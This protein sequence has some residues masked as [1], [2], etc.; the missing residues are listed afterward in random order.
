MSY[1]DPIVP[2]V[3]YFY[4]HRKGLGKGASQARRAAEIVRATRV[5]REL[6]VTEKLEPESIKSKPLDASAYPALFNA[7]RIPTKP[8]D[9]FEIYPAQGNENEHVI[10]LR[11]DRLWKVGTKGLG[12]EDLQGAFQQIIKAADLGAS[13][14]DGAGIGTLTGE[15]RDVW[16]EARTHLLDLSPLNAE[17]LKSIQSSIVIVNLDDTL[18]T[19]GKEEREGRSWS[20]YTGDGKPGRNRW[21]DK[22]EFVVDPNGESGFNGERGS[23][24]RFGSPAL[25]VAFA[26]PKIPP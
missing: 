21:F 8:S 17:I 23:L 1:R 20:L 25:L 16:T 22:H 13:S 4:L 6:V 12:V 2:N 3:N 18:P 15:D 9:T 19:E 14:S 26:D 5:F 7:S 10:V 11:K 24:V